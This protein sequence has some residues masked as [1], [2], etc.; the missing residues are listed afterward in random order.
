MTGLIDGA[1]SR[2]RMVL[3][4][5]VCAIL[6]GLVTYIELPK[7]AEPDIQ[8]P[9]VGV[10]IPL[11]GASPEDIER[12]LVRPTEVELQ[13][14]EGVK[15][16]NSFA[17]EGAAQFFIEFEITS[18]LDQALVDVRD[19][20]DMAKREFPDE[21]REPVVQ[22]I[23]AALFPVL[24]INLSGQL[25]ERTLYALA[26]DLEDELESLSGVL[27]ADVLGVREDVLEVIIDPIKLE[28]YNISHQELIATVQANNRL[29]TAGSLDLGQ[30]RYSVKVP[31]LIKTSED[32]QSLPVKQSGDAVVTL[33]DVADIRRTFKDRTQYARFDG[34]PAVTLEIVKR[35]GANILDTVQQARSVVEAEQ[36]DWPDS[37]QVTMTSDISEEIED[38]LSHLEG[39]IL[40]AIFLVMI[41]VVAVMGL[42]PALLVGISIPACFMMGFIL[43]AAAGYTINMMVMF[44]LVIAVG[45]LVDGAIVIVEY[46]DRKIAEGLSPIEAFRLAGKRM[47]WPIVASTATTLAAFVPFLFWD[48]I[49]GKFMA[50][51]PITLMFVLFSSL[52]MALVFLP[53]LAGVVSRKSQADTEAMKAISGAGG[54]PLT[55]KSWVG[56]YARLCKILID[57]P[58]SVTV[59]TIVL[60]GCIFGAFQSTTHKTVLFI[61]VEP[62]QAYVFVRAQGNISAEEEFD[63]VRKV[64]DI[65][66]QVPGL[67]HVSMQSGSSAS[68]SS[69]GDGLGDIPNDAVGQILVEIDKES[70]AVDGREVV[71]DIRQRLD[72]FAGALIEIKEPEQGPPVGKDIQVALRS[73]DTGLLY[74]TTELIRRHLDTM[75]GLIEVE[76]TRPLP[77]TEWRIEVDREEAA[78]Y[79][80]NVSQVGQVVQ[81]MTNGLLLGKYRPDD[82][83]E[84]VDIRLRLPE[85]RRTIEGMD[86]LRLAT[87][88]GMVPISAFMERVPA[89]RTNVVERLNGKRIFIVKANA[90]ISGTGSQKIAEIK[91]WLATQ[92]IDP[93]VEVSFE[94]ADEEAGNATGFFGKAALA[95]LFLMGVILL[96]EFNNFYHVG[97]TLT[98]VVLSLAGVVL[99]L[100]LATDYISVIMS[101]TGVV[102][103]AGVV[104]NNNIVLLDTFQRFRRDG[105][106]PEDAAI[107]AAAQ[108]IRPI[109]MTSLTTIC[110]LMP[111]MFMLNV[112][113]FSG[114][115]S[116]G[117]TNAEFWVPLS[118]VMIFGLGFSTVLI[119]LVTPVWLTV[120]SQLGAWRDR[121][122]VRFGLKSEQ[123]EAYR[124]PED[125]HQT[126]GSL[127]AAE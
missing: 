27:R 33:S 95:T 1:I 76:D 108:R 8:F 46:G 38:R 55:Q 94:G 99:G 113:F 40:T 32:L 83:N 65:L 106:D 122:L 101:G 43:L 42:R 80:V 12:L 37:I 3:A 47:F 87:G 123:E 25:P 41:I 20:V 14:I 9:F 126:S 73:D 69:F 74:D 17:F 70:P 35:S 119:L 29:I 30:G 82:V 2:A 67:L 89:P 72:G 61:D 54:D 71:A 85:E 52:L 111:M 75:D 68:S 7:E 88:S 112:N 44:G 97:L 118:T 127:K 58:L 62:E 125:S 105:R 39:A 28:S 98:A 63:L 102:A 13:G 79:G 96:W 84:E 124:R 92:D 86:T 5:L 114:A 59:G 10:T 6:V 34:Q 53:V 16:L 103:L 15:E 120:P 19:K 56:R 45:I 57:R 23:S 107:A 110:G 36:K 93:G 26:R 77:G 121:L 66:M 64:E 22:E 48:T 49:Y 78:R 109:L 60:I 100:M 24:L 116:R 81:L 90:E 51:L 21:A 91:D 18:D 50:Y 31:G 115:I 104:V 4:I 11:E 117:G